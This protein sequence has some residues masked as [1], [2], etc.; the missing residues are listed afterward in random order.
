[1]R[2]N[3]VKKGR[4]TTTTKENVKFLFLDYQQREGRSKRWG[5]RSNKKLGAGKIVEPFRPTFCKWSWPKPDSSNSDITISM[6]TTWLTTMTL[7]QI[8]RMNPVQRLC[9]RLHPF[10]SA[11]LSH[12]FF[13]ESFEESR[14]IV[15][16]I[17]RRELSKSRRLL[18]IGL[19]QRTSMG[20]ASCLSSDISFNFPKCK[21]SPIIFLFIFQ[22]RHWR[23]SELN[24]YINDWSSVVKTLPIFFATLI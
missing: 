6:T 1:M 22:V 23:L 14:R 12:S 4:W 8:T 9:S 3:G 17:S 21:L 16:V 19:N 18:D 13:A 2:W 5:S 10:S 15:G 20:A 24:F 7:N 11:I